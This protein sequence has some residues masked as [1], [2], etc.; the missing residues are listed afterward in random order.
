MNP[1]IHVPTQRPGEQV[2]LLLRRHWIIFFRYIIQFIALLLFPAA[3]I[4]IL[5]FVGD[6]EVDTESIFYAVAVLV[7]SLYY[8]FILLIFFHNFV[9]YHLD[10]WVVTDQR[11]LSIEQRALFD[12]MVAELNILKV[13][14][15]TSEVKGKFQTLFDYGNVFV[16][17]GGSTERFIFEQVPR[18]EEVVKVILQVHDQA[19]QREQLYLLQQNQQTQ[20][21]TSAVAP[22]PPPPYIHTIHEPDNL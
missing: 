8:L 17:T 11:I 20:F 2:L 4:A 12:R 19:R 15:V 13:Q 6:Y 21:S 16:Q 7:L 10:I 14:D 22:P 5:F 1:D 3:V 18:P 9:D